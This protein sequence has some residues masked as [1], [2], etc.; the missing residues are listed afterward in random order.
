MYY[1]LLDDGNNDKLVTVPEGEENVIDCGMG[2]IIKVLDSNYGNG[3]HKCERQTSLD[4]VI[5]WYVIS[6]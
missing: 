4:I 5:T 2:S 1:I 3:V 6:K